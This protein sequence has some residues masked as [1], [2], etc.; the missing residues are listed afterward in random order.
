MNK[1]GQPWLDDA[2][3]LIQAHG[4]MILQHDGTYYWYGENKGVANYLNAAGVNMVPFVGIS[5]YSSLDLKTWHNAGIVLS[6]ATDP[7]NTLTQAS[8]CERPKVLY[9]AANQHF[10]MWCH[11]DT[12][13]YKFAGNLVAVATGPT[14]PFQVQKVLRPNGKESRDMTLFQDGDQAYLIH[15]SDMNKTLYFSELTEDFTGFT[16]FNAK[17]F[18]DQE[19][20]APTVFHE[21]D[22]YF[23]ITSGCTGWRP[24]PALFSRGHFLFSN[25]KLINN[26]CTGPKASTTYDGQPTFVLQVD[27]H[28]YLMLDHWQRFDLKH[29]GYSILPIDIQGR[30]L[31]IPWVEQPF[32]GQL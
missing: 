17:A 12:P 23:T 29:S 20:E 32:G 2:G 1:N 5:C 14:G 31:T 27:G 16:G 24:N 26:P 8:I 10:V 30:D 28:Y 4:G 9:D 18:V 19:R 15:S 6:Q 21:G 3:D 7:T 13:D 22:W 25:Q 11:Y